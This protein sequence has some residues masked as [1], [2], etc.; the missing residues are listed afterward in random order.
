MYKFQNMLQLT[1]G[2][3]TFSMSSY[4][5]LDE[6]GRAHAFG[7]VQADD[8][9]AVFS[10]AGSGFI[11]LGLA[12][13]CVTF[14]YA[15]LDQR[16]SLTV[17]EPFH[18]WVGLQNV[19]MGARRYDPRFNLPAL[20][21]YSHF[22]ARPSSLDELNDLR[23]RG[24]ISGSDFAN[25]TSLFDTTTGAPLVSWVDAGELHDLA[26]KF[27][28]DFVG[29][30]FPSS[31]PQWQL[32]VPVVGYVF[33]DPRILVRLLRISR[34]SAPDALPGMTPVNRSEG[35]RCIGQT[36]LNFV[37]ATANMTSN[38]TAEA[39]SRGAS[40][41]LRCM[42][43]R[44]TWRTWGVGHIWT[45]HPVALAFYGSSVMLLVCSAYLLHFFHHALFPEAWDAAW[46]TRC[47][48][49]ILVC[50]T[51]GLALL[52][53][54]HDVTSNFLQAGGLVLSLSTFLFSASSVLDYP[55]R[56]SEFRETLK[57]EPHPLMVC[58]WLNMPML[59]PAPMAAVVLAGYGRDMYS[60]WGV[61]VVG[62]MIGIMYMVRFL[63]G[64]VFVF[65]HSILSFLPRLLAEGVLVHLER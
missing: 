25:A 62:A 47:I 59:F 48:Q 10:A 1:R 13:V 38:V 17:L 4:N 32:P 52:L 39:R 23:S 12:I 34:C 20:D 11:C 49:L 43:R 35:C 63:F 18:D 44:V 55:S 46:R 45:V 8:L 56:G 65:A 28:S 37:R 36:Y 60:M 9:R 61:A 7:H 64:I 6:E 2:E 33:E 41:V 19:F 16:V 24:L 58:F 26:R 21:L 27:L 57:P 51:G 3:G 31:A 22:D 14:M 54:L 50:E 29:A 30:V 40:E 53:L 5:P 42:D 15:T